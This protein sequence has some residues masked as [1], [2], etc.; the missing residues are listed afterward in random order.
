MFKTLPVFRY[1]I[2][3]AHVPSVHCRPLFSHNPTL[4]HPPPNPTRLLLYSRP[5]TPPQPQR[6]HMDGKQP[7]RRH[8]CDH[9]FPDG[10]KMV[11]GVVEHFP[12]PPPPSHL[13][14]SALL[15]SCGFYGWVSPFF[16]FHLPF[17]TCTL[18]MQFTIAISTDEMIRWHGF[19]FI[20]VSPKII[21]F[22]SH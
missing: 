20:D 12:L 19:N 2:S 22:R 7:G 5:C 21:Q 4:P 6:S 8:A 17:H 16:C 18:P 10:E 3:Q 14:S 15:V 13:S 9:K 1:N 11:G